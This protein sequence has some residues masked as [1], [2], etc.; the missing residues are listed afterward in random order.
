MADFTFSCWKIFILFPGT[1]FHS[2]NN[3]SHF[4]WYHSTLE[5]IL[6][7]FIEASF[8]LV[9]NVQETKAKSLV[10]FKFLPWQ[11]KLIHLL[12][13]FCS[14]WR[15][16][17]RLQGDFQLPKQPKQPAVRYWGQLR[18]GYSHWS[19]QGKKRVQNKETFIL[20]DPSVHQSKCDHLH[21]TRSNIV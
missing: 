13:C 7:S 9:L 18:L 14:L 6:K 3:F 11:H 21:V 10:L 2:G 1:T 8:I 19:Q 12:F 15:I 20:P 16:S 5:E 4:L 17:F